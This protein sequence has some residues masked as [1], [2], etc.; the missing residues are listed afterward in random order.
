MYYSD[1]PLS[2]PGSA[3][4]SGLLNLQE[5]EGLVLRDEDVRVDSAM[6]VA[7]VLGRL[8]KLRKLDLHGW[9]HSDAADDP[10]GAVAL[11]GSLRQLSALHGQHSYSQ[12]EPLGQH[13]QLWVVS[14]YTSLT[15]WQAN[16]HLYCPLIPT[17]AYPYQCP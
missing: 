4:A 13:C 6:A 12:Q 8:Q 14:S 2:V 10:R 7:R 5:L 3:L 9:L 1:G 17:K 16:L 15:T 11:A